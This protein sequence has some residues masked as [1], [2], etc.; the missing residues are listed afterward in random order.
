MAEAGGIQVR[1]LMFPLDSH[2]EA[3][4]KCVSVICDD[5]SFDDL[6]SGYTSENQCA[7]GVAKVEET[8]T[9]LR[10]KG[11]GSTPTYIFA[12]MTPDW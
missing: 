5:K 7:E 6:E 8:I 4:T 1:V 10:R 12:A 11:I 3:K 2:P 9:Y